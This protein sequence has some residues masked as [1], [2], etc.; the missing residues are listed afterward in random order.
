MKFRDSVTALAVAVAASL[1]LALPGADRMEGWSIDLL[2]Y[3]RAKMDNASDIVPPA[4][5]NAVVIAIDEETFRTRPFADAPKVMW[6]PEIA[7][8]LEAVTNADVAVIGF[9]LIFPTSMEKYIRGFDRAFLLA[10]RHAATKNAIVLGKVQHSDKPIAPHQGQSFAVGHARNIRAVNVVEDSDGIIRRVPFFFSALNQ[11]A[12][13]RRETSLSLEMAART[14]GQAPVVGEDGAISLDGHRLTGSGSNALTLNFDTSAGAIPTY[15]LADL[16]ACA[17]AGNVE[18][19]RA[20]FAGRAVLFGEVLDVEDRKLTSARLAT[21]GFS[22]VAA[23]RCAGP[24][25]PVKTIVRDSLPGVYI[26]ATAIN[27]ILNGDALREFGPGV[28]WSLSLPLALLGAFLALGMSPIA[29]G[30]ALVIAIAGWTGASAAL[31]ASALVAPLLDPITASVAAFFTMLGYRFLIADRD[32]R[33]LRQAFTFYLAPAVIERMVSSETPPKLGGES[34]LVT[35]L[36]SDIAGFTAIS[37]RLSPSELVSF[38]NIYLTAM[39]DI[40][41]LHGGFVD[42]YI[43]DAIVAVFGAPL[44]DPDHAQRGVTAALQCRDQLAAMQD[45]FNLPSD[46]T[47]AAR[48]GLNTGVTL[49]GNIGSQRRFNYT[50]MGDTVNLAARLESINK[51]YGTTIMVSAETA[52]ACD[53]AIVFREID[54]VRV[55]GKTQPVVMMEALGFQDALGL[56]PRLVKPTTRRP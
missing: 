4:V 7:L 31:F 18:Y 32:K 28:Y 2:H 24:G 3:L 42:K 26:H 5:P 25:S 49:V 50:V 37:E 1:V 20:H 43:G 29:G 16:H 15:S 6:T 35:V 53:E 34:R 21:A 10:L 45:R 44:D 27:N 22:A 30:A 48:I 39:T 46:I 17:T 41:E 52:S 11:D 13:V 55:V 8:V 23:P 36:F 54:R 51:T 33:F 40:V 47:V 56:K 19:F 9:D 38:M 12:S 14:V